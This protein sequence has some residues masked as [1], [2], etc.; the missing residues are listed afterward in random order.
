MGIR[1]EKAGNIMKI[2]EVEWMDA[3]S[4]FSIPLSFEEIVNEE[5]LHTKS[6]GYLIYEDKNKVILGF[7]LFG[8]DMVKHWQLIPRKM[9]LKIKELK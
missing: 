2:V 7:M 5:P 3:Q 4:G 8:E 9:I 1:N 6:I